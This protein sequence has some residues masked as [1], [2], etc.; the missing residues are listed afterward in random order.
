[1]KT[2]GVPASDSTTWTSSVSM[3]AGGASPGAGIGAERCAPRSL[4]R[5][6]RAREAARG[7]I[8]GR[9]RGANCSCVQRPRVKPSV[10]LCWGSSARKAHTSFLTYATNGA[11]PCS[12]MRAVLSYEPLTKRRPSG[13]SA[14]EYTLPV[15]CGK[16]RRTAPS[17]TLKSLM[18]LSYEAESACWL[19]SAALESAV[20]RPH[21]RGPLGRRDADEARSARQ[22]RHR[23]DHGV[24]RNGALALAV[25]PHLDGGHPVC[26]DDAVVGRRRHAGNLVMNLRQF[27]DSGGAMSCWAERRDLARVRPRNERQP[28]GIPKP[29]AHR[30]HLCNVVSQRQ[31]V[32]HE[33]QR[34]CR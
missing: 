14:R 12:T 11:R 34:V 4:R 31:P 2:R 10:E 32:Q 15:W 1:M 28:R 13:S 22:R 30:R 21:L 26:G 29:G 16:V 8:S 25:A 3:G 33:A 17:L 6:W 20:E 27:G 24:S 18:V 23:T 7:E 19:S 5:R 9:R